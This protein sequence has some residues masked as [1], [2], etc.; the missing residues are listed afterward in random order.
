MH[1]VLLPS[2]HEMHQLDVRGMWSSGEVTILVQQS[3][4]IPFCLMYLRLG[5]KAMDFGSPSNH[6]LGR[7]LVFFKAVQ[8]HLEKISL[9]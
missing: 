6:S 3:H 1:I 8:G 4:G 2:H 9:C 5:S 7:D